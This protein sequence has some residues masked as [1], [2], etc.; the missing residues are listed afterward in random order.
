M[1]DIKQHIMAMNK[2][3]KDTGY[4]I[5][6]TNSVTHLFQKNIDDLKKQ[7]EAAKQNGYWDLNPYM[8]GMTNGLICALA[9][10]EGKEPEY[11]PTPEK[12]LENVV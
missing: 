11:L 9:T 7:V 2:E 6:E 1:G 4:R 3:L 5:V 10:I 12:W 8:H